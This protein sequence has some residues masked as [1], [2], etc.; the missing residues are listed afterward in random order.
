MMGGKMREKKSCLNLQFKFLIPL[1]TECVRLHSCGF[2]NFRWHWTISIT[3]LPF[4]AQTKA[5]AVLSQLGVW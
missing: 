5:S 4:E 2:D 3:S 1:W